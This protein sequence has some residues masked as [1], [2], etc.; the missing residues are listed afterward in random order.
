MCVSS[1]IIFQKDNVLVHTCQRIFIFAS[2]LPCSLKIIL[3]STCLPLA[4]K[5]KTV[6]FLSSSIF[7]WYG[8]SSVLLVMALP[9]VKDN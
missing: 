6:A 5:M 9:F 4:S 2:T 3:T 1:A 8:Y 7:P